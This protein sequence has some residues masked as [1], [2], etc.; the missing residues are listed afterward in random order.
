MG[1]GRRAELA[2]SIPDEIPTA[3]AVWWGRSGRVH[4]CRKQWQSRVHTQKS[5]RGAGKAKSISVYMPQQSN[6]GD[7]HRPRGI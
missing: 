4:S 5:A 3:M 6:M 1:H 2:G 7:G